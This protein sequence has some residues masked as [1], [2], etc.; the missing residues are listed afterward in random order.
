MIQE[1][2]IEKVIKISEKKLIWFDLFDFWFKFIH[3]YD[4][5]L[6]STYEKNYAIYM[7]EQNFLKNKIAHWLYDDFNVIKTVS[8]KTMYHVWIDNFYSACDAL[9]NSWWKY[10]CC[11]IMSHCSCFAFHK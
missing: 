2:M 1:N 10:L 9:I 8:F 3:S 4:I 6:D 5:N 7:N 11:L